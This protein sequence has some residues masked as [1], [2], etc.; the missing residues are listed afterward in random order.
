MC[1]GLVG[2]IYAIP[3]FTR[4]T[5][6][7]P[8]AMPTNLTPNLYLLMMLAIAPYLLFGYKLQAKAKLV[9]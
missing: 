2:L 5:K 8:F 3:P 4:W 1:V 6:G 9:P 7:G